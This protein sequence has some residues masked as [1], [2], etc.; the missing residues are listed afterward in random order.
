MKP[1]PP[2]TSHVL[3]VRHDDAKD[4]L[5]DRLPAGTVEPASTVGFDS[6]SMCVS[7]QPARSP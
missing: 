2:V 5:A 7:K 4:V 1:A 6:R 3:I